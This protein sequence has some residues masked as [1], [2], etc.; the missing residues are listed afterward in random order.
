MKKL[1]IITTGSGSY[2]PEIKRLPYSQE[3]L[4]LAREWAEGYAEIY[5][6]V[7]GIETK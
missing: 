3:A 5:N 4:K 6:C 7:V 2:Q 1:I